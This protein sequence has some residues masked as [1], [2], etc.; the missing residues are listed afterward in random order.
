MSHV[1]GSCYG[2]GGYR[3]RHRGAHGQPPAHACMHALPM[4]PLPPFLH[5]PVD[6]LG[7]SASPPRFSINRGTSAPAAG[8]PRR[9]QYR[10]TLT[11]GY[12]PHSAR[13]THNPCDCVS[14]TMLDATRGFASS[15]TAPR[16]H[17]CAALAIP[18][19]TLKLDAQDEEEHL[20]PESPHALHEYR[21]WSVSSQGA[22]T[23]PGSAV[24]RW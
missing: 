12:K 21:F 22:E 18:R 13:S 11:A 14:T 19:A 4:P 6:A 2:A 5:V 10:G 7:C 20:S 17:A 8:R 1:T 24:V 3:R 15:G 9:P 23:C 16:G